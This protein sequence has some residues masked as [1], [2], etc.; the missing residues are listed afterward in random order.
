MIDI[1][2]QKAPSLLAT[3]VRKAKFFRSTMKKTLA[4]CR[5]LPAYFHS[6]KFLPFSKY[7]QGF[8]IPIAELFLEKVSK[9]FVTNSGLGN[10]E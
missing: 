5:A 4:D 6:A 7:R 8:G 9:D 1:A 3:P 2:F 10:P